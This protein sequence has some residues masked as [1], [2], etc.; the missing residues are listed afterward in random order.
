M[1]RDPYDAFSRI[2]DAW[3]AGYSKAFSEAVLPFYEREIMHRM[4]PDRSIADVACGTGTFLVAWAK[5][6]PQ[7]R[8]FGADRSAGMLRVARRNLKGASVSARLLHLSMQELTLPRSVGAIVSVFDSVN[9]LTRLADL[10]NFLARARRSLLPGG[11]LLFDINDERAFPRLFSGSWTVERE[12]LF[13]A[14]TGECREDESRGLLRFTAFER[15]RQGWRRSD[16]SIEERNW[17][18]P[19]IEE[20]IR[21]AGLLPLRARKIQPYPPDEVDAP[22]T[23]WICRRPEKVDPRDARNKATWGGKD[24]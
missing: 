18:R 11:L 6:H 5:R 24:P 4:T 2:Y 7:W 21:R 13:V 15:T 12:D 10:R 16:F 9:H 19:E 1:H 20:A 22:R 17:R 23:L 3:Q 8:L 14:A